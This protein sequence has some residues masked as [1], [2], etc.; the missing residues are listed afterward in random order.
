M[1]TRRGFLVTSG[2]GLAAV[3]AAR[4]RLASAR[5]LL[6]DP[7]LDEVIGRGLAAAKAAGAT[8]ADVRL[9]RQRRESVSTR[10]DHVTGVGYEE[11]YGVGIRVIAGGAWGFAASARVEPN[12]FHGLAG[13]ARAAELA[14][15]V[16]RAR[17]HYDR[18]LAVAA[19][20]DSERPEL[21][22]ARAALG[23]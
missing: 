15:D 5:G 10:E 22:L 7:L 3:A 14:G 17:T 12:R 13:A 11:N 20:A 19:Q 1:L 6:T 16:E 2:A 21:R 8:Y 23:R 4:S 18:L 9:Q